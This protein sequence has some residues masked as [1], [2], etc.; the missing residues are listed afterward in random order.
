MRRLS[1]AIIM[2]ALLAGPAWAEPPTSEIL[3]TL[4]QVMIERSAAAKCAVPD[5]AKAA[6]FRKYYQGIAAEAQTAL[7]SL[8][9]DLD[10]SHIEKVMV[11]HYDEIDRRVAAI[12]A[13]ESCD[14]SHIKEALQKYDSIANAVITEQMAKK[15]E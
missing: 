1:A 15:S 11:Q 10:L 8:A 2:L 3:Q 14:G 7:K 12:V 9:S 4:D 6:A 13:Q 5:S